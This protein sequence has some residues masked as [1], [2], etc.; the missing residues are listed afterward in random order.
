MLASNIIPVFIV[1]VI[2]LGLSEEQ[3]DTLFITAKGLQL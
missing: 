1:A 2:A 3:L